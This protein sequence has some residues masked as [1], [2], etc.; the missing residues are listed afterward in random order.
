MISKTLNEQIQ[1]VLDAG[2]GDLTDVII[3]FGEKNDGFEEAIEAARRFLDRF[4]DYHELHAYL[5]SQNKLSEEQKLREDTVRQLGEQI[6]Q[7]QAEIDELKNK[8]GR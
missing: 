1:F 4:G 6:R 7:L 8:A 2:G 5:G 3:Q